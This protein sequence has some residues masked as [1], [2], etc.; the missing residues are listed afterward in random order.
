MVTS[1]P[2]ALPISR[3]RCRASPTWLPI[4]WRGDSE[5]IGSWKMI[6]MRPPRIARMAFPS[7]FSLAISVVAPPFA[8]S[9]N[10]ISP[11]LICA[12]LGRIPMID[13]AM[14]DL[15]DPDSPTT[16]TVEPW[17]MVR[18]TSSTAVMKEP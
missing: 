17:R 13:W 2:S 18:D 11:P 7:R 10:R 3:C 14:V 8:G 4:V 5:V 15:P 12:T 1:R 9:W 16:A 6:E